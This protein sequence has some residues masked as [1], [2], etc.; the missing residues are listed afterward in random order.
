[1]ISKKL[2]IMKALTKHLQGITPAW[3]DLPPQMA[4]EVCP[5]DLSQSVFRGRL[6]F[7]DEVKNPF[8]AILEAPRQLDPNG[9]GNDLVQDED[10]TLLIQGFADDDQRNPLDPAYSLLAWTQMRMSRITAQKK[11]SLPPLWGK[12][13]GPSSTRLRRKIPFACRSALMSPMGHRPRA[14]IPISRVGTA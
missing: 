10:W 8:L 1:M 3:T 5:Y 4:G 6:E 7:G 14:C 11:T 2:A 12:R 13:W 9:A